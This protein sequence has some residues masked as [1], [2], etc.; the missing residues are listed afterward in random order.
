M[1]GHERLVFMCFLLTKL[2]AKQQKEQRTA[3]LQFY[4]NIFFLH[5]GPF[6]TEQKKCN[7]P[8]PTEQ[9]KCLCYI[10]ICFCFKSAWYITWAVGF[11]NGK[12]ESPPES[13]VKSIPPTVEPLVLEPQ[14]SVSVEAESV[15]QKTQCSMNQN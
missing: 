4:W 11:W 9:K 10:D 7:G 5:D 14:K 6:P 2:L 8:F 13:A 3:I 12:M 15:S 1:E